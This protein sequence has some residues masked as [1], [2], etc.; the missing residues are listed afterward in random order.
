MMIPAYA[1][2]SRASRGFSLIEL[3]VA[4]A[5]GL[6]MIG[7]VV[8]VFVS[9]QQTARTK[10]ELDRAQEAF[11]FASHTIMRVVQQGEIRES[12]STLT[13]PELLVVE[14]S[15]AVGHKD[16][17]GNDIPE[18][19]DIDRVSNT[20]TIVNG[21]LLCSVLTHMTDDSSVAPSGSPFTIVTGIDATRSAFSFGTPST[22]TTGY[23]SDNAQWVSANLVNDWPNVRSV[24][25]RLA[26]QS[27]G[28]A[29]GPT[30]L[31]SATMRCGAQ[32]FC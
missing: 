2:F 21:Q 20:F 17:V 10:Q 24:R 18:G 4:L 25:V 26:M 16:C 29:I 8:T 19:P 28:D 6:I 3:M 1:Q 15:P 12:N 13:P 23:W 22:G 5:L 11:R 32:N 27:G 9:N 30:A 7:A 14:V 31:F